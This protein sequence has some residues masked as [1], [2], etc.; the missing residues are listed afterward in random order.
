[1]TL[2][3]KADAGKLIGQW[4][5]FEV[6]PGAPYPHTWEGAVGCKYFRTRSGVE[7]WRNHLNT[8]ARP[9]DEFFYGYTVDQ[10]P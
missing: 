2:K 6:G 4:A 5:V 7:R 8:T 10:I 1:M 9:H 3:E